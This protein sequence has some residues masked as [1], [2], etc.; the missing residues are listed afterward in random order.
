MAGADS[1]LDPGL[2]EEFKFVEQVRALFRAAGVSLAF[3]EAYCL[4]QN[5][6][7]AL[8]RVAD[9]ASG[10]AA[11]AVPDVPSDI[12]ESLRVLRDR[13]GPIVSKIRRM[14]LARPRTPDEADLLEMAL[15]VIIGSERG[16]EAVGRWVNEPARYAQEAGDR[17]QI[18]TRRLEAVQELLRPAPAKASSTPASASPGSLLAPSEIMISPPAV[19]EGLSA[20]PGPGRVALAWNAV[21]GASGYNV[22]RSE[23]EGARFLTIGT[24]SDCAYVDEKVSPGSAYLYA[25][26]ASSE[27]GEG[28]D[29]PSARA[30]LPAPPPAPSGVTAAPGIG[31]VTL[32]WSAAPGATWYR[33]KRAPNPGGPYSLLA[34]LEGNSFVDGAAKQGESSSYVVQALG[35]G[36][37]G[38]D[39]APQRAA[40]L[41]PPAAPAGL[42]A[43]AGISRVTLTWTAVREATGYVVR[44]APGPGD[45]PGPVGT[46]NR[47][48]FV[49]AA[50][51]NGTA[52]IYVVRATNAQGE[53]ADSA[54]AAATPA[55]P[56][57]A[58]SGLAASSDGRSVRVTWSSVPGATS[59]NVKRSA[60][61]GGPYGTI[62]TG[63]KQTQHDDVPPTR[64]AKYHY[65]VSAAGPGGEGPPSAEV[66]RTLPAPPA[67]PA[68]LTASAGHGRITLAWLPSAGA[69]RYHVK[70]RVGSGSKYVTLASPAGP[71]HVDATVAIGS[72]YQYVVSAVSGEMES[73]DSPPLRAEP[74]A[75]PA[76]PAGLSAQ[77]GKGRVAL[78]WAASPGA[79]EYRIQRSAARD[80]NFEEIARVQ[81]STSYVDQKVTNGLS[82]DYLVIAATSGGQSPTSARVRATP[83]SAPEAPR[84]LQGSA[85]QGRVL[86]TWSPAAGAATY[87]VKRAGSAEGPYVEVVTTKETTYTDAS[88]VNGTTYYYRVSA[89]NAG[90]GSDDAGPLQATPVDQPSAPGGL[91]VSPGDALISLS[92]QASAG[93]ATYTVK[94]ASAPRGPFTT[95]AVVEVTSYSDRD[96]DNRTT[97]HYTVTAMNAAGRSAASEAASAS[98]KPPAG[99]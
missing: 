39:S 14:F 5:N 29:S 13:G 66:S 87:A 91:I 50:V 43:S 67:A 44:R 10:A 68:G 75:V 54:P 90:G 37:E 58:P 81:G 80:E 52:Y 23:A 70:R 95:I 49:D 65:V 27:A 32:T 6:R 15:A 98:P 9:R 71:T 93:A 96:V 1:T 25:V 19:P 31:R 78:S 73:P 11:D 83:I 84:N 20:T 86:L 97:Y 46:V 3:W 48:S 17:I 76:A 55:A 61:P 89:A 99:M 4:S 85:S 72:S 82:Y 62:V 28:P 40:P 12:L 57:S 92:W 34:T 59:Y 2:V 60:V 7:G 45:A 69:S 74:L 77:A 24:P 16:R 26:S 18:L 63:V 51:S 94:R 56:P 79:V 41:A 53:S 36:G 8:R 42:R 88:V 33:V 38:P 30:A 35:P 64:G 47:T 21:P 22:K